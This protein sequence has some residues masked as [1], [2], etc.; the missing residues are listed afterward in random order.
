MDGSKG[1]R[2]R[3]CVIDKRM[4]VLEADGHIDRGDDG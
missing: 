2:L 1:G 4:A 3:G